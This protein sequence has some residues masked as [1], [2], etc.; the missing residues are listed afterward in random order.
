MSPNIQ[1]AAC[2]LRRSSLRFRCAFY[3]RSENGGEAVHLVDHG[4]VFE[5]AGSEE[6][7][8]S[9]LNGCGRAEGHLVVIFTQVD[10]LVQ[11][12]ATRLS[13]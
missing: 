4:Q 12:T 11:V 9:L 10:N 6:K 8:V 5:G 3:L 13:K 1:A 2:Q 7:S